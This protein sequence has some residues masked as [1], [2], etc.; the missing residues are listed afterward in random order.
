[1]GRKKKKLDS[2]RLFTEPWCPLFGNLPEDYLPHSMISRCVMIIYLARLNWGIFNDWEDNSYPTKTLLTAWAIF[3]NIPRITYEARYPGYEEPDN[4]FIDKLFA[5]INYKT[6]G[7]L[8]EVSHEKIFSLLAID[9]AWDVIEDILQKGIPENDE[10]VLRRVLYASNL[11]SRADSYKD[12]FI[13][14]SQIEDTETRAQK[15]KED[16]RKRPKILGQKGGKAKGNSEI[17]KLKNADW[18]SRASKHSVEKLGKSRVAELIKRDIK[19]EI[20]AL[21]K[22]IEKNF[23]QGLDTEDMEEELKKLRRFDLSKDYISRKI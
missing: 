18:E 5:V 21:V 14:N 12:A 15:L 20:N 8:E 11:L 9:F 1:M 3:K 23:E 10:T 19:K 13:Y 17:Y 22:E 6:E 16:I 2:E 7:V 4:P